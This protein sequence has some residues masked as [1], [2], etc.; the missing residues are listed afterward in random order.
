MRKDGEEEGEEESRKARLTKI[1]RLGLN[2]LI[3]CLILQQAR[4]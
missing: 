4:N 2:S 3:F 1:S